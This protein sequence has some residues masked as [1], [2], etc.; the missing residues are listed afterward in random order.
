MCIFLHTLTLHTVFMVLVS[1]SFIIENTG[2]ESLTHKDILQVY[3]RVGVCV[4]V[5]WSFYNFTDM[6]G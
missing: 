6:T 1:L 5:C 2:N 4:S 3:L